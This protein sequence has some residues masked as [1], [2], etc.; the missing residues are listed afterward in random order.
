MLGAPRASA[1]LRGAI[2]ELARR[3]REL[4][5]A[6]RGARP[7]IADIRLA[8][9]DRRDPDSRASP[10][11]RPRN[12]RSVEPARPSR[13]G[14]CRLGRRDSARCRPRFDVDRRRP[15]AAEGRRM[16]PAGGA[17]GEQLLL[18]WRCASCRSPGARRCFRFTASAVRSTTSPTSGGLRPRRS[19]WRNWSAGAPT[20]PRCSPQRAPPHLAGLDEAVRRYD[21]GA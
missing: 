14:R 5:G 16:T 17:C 6:R 19:A 15:N 10:R 2:A 12:P 18:H 3:A 20:S 13:Q 21:S 1:A 7:A 9:R 8:A 4:D 11:A